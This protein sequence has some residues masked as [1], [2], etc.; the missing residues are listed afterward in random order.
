MT[1]KT[2]S[3]VST[4]GG[5]G[6]RT[7]LSPER[8]PQQSLSGIGLHDPLHGRQACPE[9]DSLHPGVGQISPLEKL[10]FCRSLP[11]REYVFDTPFPANR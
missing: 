2:P 8:S 10:F 7:V 5:D 1:Q 9:F 11:N 4:I 3:S 6:D